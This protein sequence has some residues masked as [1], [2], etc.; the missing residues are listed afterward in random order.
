MKTET[1]PGLL[2]V[3]ISLVKR[4]IELEQKIIEKLQIDEVLIPKL[5]KMLRYNVWTINQF[6]DIS[7]LAVSTI[8]N[9]TRPL[10]DKTTGTMATGLDYCY[11]HEYF[12]SLGAKMIVRNEKSEKYL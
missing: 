12:G 6:A 9:L 7:G 3:E 8:N 10:F 5:R 11:P 2:N 1:I 4:D